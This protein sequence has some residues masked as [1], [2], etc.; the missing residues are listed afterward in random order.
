[1]KYTIKLIK[2]NY[3]HV[4]NEVNKPAMTI[5]NNKFY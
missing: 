1:M 5:L 3:F 4:N 2:F